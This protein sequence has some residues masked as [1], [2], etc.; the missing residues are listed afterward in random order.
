MILALMTWFVMIGF[1]Y[2]KKSA[3]SGDLVVG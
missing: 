3:G 1:F 2:L